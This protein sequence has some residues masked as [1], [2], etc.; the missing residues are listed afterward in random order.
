MEY[1]SI[2]KERKPLQTS[3][4]IKEG[5]DGKSL[6]CALRIRNMRTAAEEE[7]VILMDTPV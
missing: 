5:T 7:T 6:L 1:Q 3:R 4:V 2:Q